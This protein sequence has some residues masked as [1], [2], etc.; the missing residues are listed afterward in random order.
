MVK[1][2]PRRRPATQADVEK[3]KKQAQSEAVKYAFAIFFTVLYDKEHADMEVM[4]RVWSEI[5]ELSESITQGYVTVSDLM[6]TLKREY[7]V[8][9]E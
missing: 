4:K 6:D 9:F 5:S 8:V 1:P 3:A 7:D 2:N